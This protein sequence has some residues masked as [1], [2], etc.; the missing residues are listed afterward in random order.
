MLLIIDGRHWMISSIQ[1]Q[2][3]YGTNWKTYP[4]SQTRSPQPNPFLRATYTA[5]L[6]TLPTQVLPDLPPPFLGLSTHPSNLTGLGQDYV[7]ASR[8]SDEP[9]PDYTKGH[10]NFF[11]EDKVYTAPNGEKRVLRTQATHDFVPTVHADDLMGPR[12]PGSKISYDVTKLFP[13]PPAF[14]R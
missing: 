1:R 10:R 14:F 11:F 12:R 13:R 2:Q 3:R 7:V 4:L 6:T 8:H 5:F 9:V